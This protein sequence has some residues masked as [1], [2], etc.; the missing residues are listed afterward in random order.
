MV[1]PPPLR[2]ADQHVLAAQLGQ[3]PPGYVAGV[4]AVHV[5]R[6][7]LCPV[8]QPQAVPLDQRLHAAQRGE[9]GQQGHVG[10]VEVLVVQ[11]ERQLLG[12]R[13]GLEMRV[14]HLPV[15]GDQ[16]FAP[17]GRAHRA[18]PSAGSGASSAAS[19]GSV[20]PS[21]Y[22]R[23]APPPV[24]MCENELS[25]KPSVRT[26]AAESPPPTTVSPGTSLI[27]WATLRVPA[28]NAGNSNTPTGPFQNTVPASLSLPANS[29]L[30]AGPMSRL[31]RSAGK[32]ATDTTSCSASAAKSVAATRSTGSTT[33]TPLRSASAS[34]SDTRSSMSAS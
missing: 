22:S 29:A 25:G 34:T 27:D 26:A 4:G 8:G 10:G 24:E 6:E 21:R 32:S 20:R 30:V 31:S 17:R 5:G 13:D 15:A 9:R 7:I 3:H 12:Q 2:V 33:S 1:V 14:V 28:A 16:G 11:R 19:P 23:L 18:V